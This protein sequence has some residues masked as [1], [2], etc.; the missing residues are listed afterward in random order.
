MGAKFSYALTGLA[1]GLMVSWWLMLEVS[2]DQA[3][4]GHAGQVSSRAMAPR[5]SN[6]ALP[7]GK[8][9]DTHVSQPHQTS[10]ARYAAPSLFRS[11]I[12]DQAKRVDQADRATLESFVA[13]VATGPLRPSG[14]IAPQRANASESPPTLA[15]PHAT[16]PPASQHSNG[17]AVR[18]LAT[19]VIVPTPRHVRRSEVAHKLRLPLHKT[20]TSLKPISS[21]PFPYDGRMPGKGSFFLNASVDGRPAHRTGSGRLYVA[22]ETYS[23]NRSLL[24]L[25]R[26]FNVNASGAIVLYFHGHGA[27]LK[28][29]IWK[30]QQLPQQITMSG[31][32]AALVAPQFAVDA[33]DS[34]IGRF[35]KPGA[36]R[37]YLDEVAGELARL[38]GDSKA[39]AA[40]MRMP[41]IIVGYS[42][43]YLP[44]AWAIVNGGIRDRVL[45]VVLLDALY[46]HASTFQNFIST[47]RRAFFISA[48]GQSTQHGN[49]RFKAWLEEAGNSVAQSMPKVLD[50]G[51]IAVIKATKRHRDYVTNAWTPYPLAD[52]LRRAPS[53]AKI[54][55]ENRYASRH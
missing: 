20:Q 5:G 30:R 33:R 28:R 41:I 45:G 11:S 55:T 27:K 34:S 10:V 22:D 23:D 32:N 46:G 7:A 53:L 48:Y 3:F 39:E 50:P 52:V 2:P 37:R 4:L 25:P 14:T 8:S 38:Y 17:E 6:K 12:D 51:T 47:Q 26:G 13:A 44:A 16:P 21:S 36:L 18:E 43:G 1:T 49:I 35:W 42:G 19:P 54:G 40:F 24:H 29:D 9:R 15:S 31:M